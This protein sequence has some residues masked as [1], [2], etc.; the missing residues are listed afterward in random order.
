[1]METPQT[2]FYFFMNKNF[3]LLNTTCLQINNDKYLNL[4]NTLYARISTASSE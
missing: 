2:K 1:M 4:Q 3:F